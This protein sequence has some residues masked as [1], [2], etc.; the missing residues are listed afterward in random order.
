[1][2]NYATLKAAIQAVIKTNGNNEITGELLQQSLL[3]MIGSLGADY[4]FAGVAVPTTNPG[5]PDQN[6]FYLA[7][8]GLYPNFGNARVDTG[9]IRAFKWNGAWDTTESL[10]VGSM[11]GYQFGGVVTPESSVPTSDAKLFFVACTE[12]EYNFVDEVGDHIEV[13]EGEVAI[14]YGQRPLWTKA[15]VAPHKSLTIVTD[16]PDL[17]YNESEPRTIADQMGHSIADV[18]STGA[19]RFV[20][21]VAVSYYKVIGYYGAEGGY[22]TF[23]G[24]DNIY[25]YDVNASGYI[26]DEKVTSLAP[27]DELSENSENAVQNKVVKAA[28]DAMD[29]AKQDKDTNA[30]A[31]NVA[32]MDANGNS[33]GSNVPLNK[34]AKIDGQYDTLIS[35]YAG[36]LIDK[37]DAGSEQQIMFRKTGGTTEVAA[38]TRAMFKRLLGRSLVWNQMNPNTSLP[39]GTGCNSTYDAT[40]HVNTITATDGTGQVRIVGARSLNIPAEHVVLVR[41]NVIDYSFANADVG[42]IKVRTTWRSDGSGSAG[43]VIDYNDGAHANALIRI[44]SDVPSNVNTLFYIDINA[45][46]AFEHSTSDYCTFYYNIVDLTVMYGAGYEPATVAEFENVYNKPYYPHNAGTFIH[47]L[48][49][50]YEAIGLNQWDE[51][52]EE[53]NINTTTGGNIAETGRIRSKNLIPVFPNTKYYFKV[54]NSDTSNRICFYDANGVFISG[55]NYT[56][57]NTV[58]TIPAGCWYTRFSPR[59]YGNTYNHDICINLSNTDLNGT[60]APYVKATATL[61]LSAFRVKDGQGNITTIHGLKGTGATYNEIDVEEK[62]YIERMAEIDLGTLNYTYYPAQRRFVATPPIQLAVPSAT[63]E[64]AKALSQI[65]TAAS[66]EDVYNGNVD[67][68]LAIS[69]AGTLNLSNSAYTDEVTFKAAMAGVKAIVPLAEPVVYDLVDDMP[70]YSQVWGVGT[71]NILPEGVDE[72]G[73]PLTTPLRAVIY[74]PKDY[75]GIINNLPKNYI[76]KDSLTNMLNALKSAGVITSFTMTWNAET[77]TYNFTIS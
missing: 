39:N 41:L 77:Q 1:M 54:P 13:A 19:V 51:E 22:I 70:E 33:K 62:K 59:T 18:L 65:Y 12:G 40:T 30:V 16:V 25:Q 38:S 31:G 52:W 36:N 47:N 2:A 37:S 49:Q 64:I 35:G 11:D 7:G 29:A 72:N 63:T 55:G 69:S 44:K 60:Y 58:I 43:T 20:G 26:T 67:K 74:Y 27:D 76:S 8:P 75:T 34:V 5:T 46:L 56:T 28:F 53:G 66:F 71:E 6:V 57:F 48:V 14:I 42:L 15:V 32:V 23:I 17:S 68:G 73:V 9:E 61:G 10:I 3:A 45:A 21:D 50:T 4:Q 24:E